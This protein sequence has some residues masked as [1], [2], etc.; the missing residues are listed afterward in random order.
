[1]TF[2]IFVTWVL[3]GVLVGLAAGMV[4]KQGGL[5][6]KNDIFLGVAG[7]IGMSWLLRGIGL[8]SGSSMVAAAFV[9]LL[10]A[11][12]AIAVQRRLRPTKQTREERADVWWR[13]GLGAV[14]VV[15][16]SWM[17]LAPE[18]QSVA[19]AA[20]TED[21]TYAV[22]PSSMKLKAGLVTGEVT[23][24]KITE[25]VE[26]GSGRVVATAKLTARIALKNSSTN[27]TVR[28]VTGKV[29]YIDAKGQPIKLEDNRA[30]PIVKFSSNDRLDPG[31]ETTESLDVDFPAEALKA[32]ALKSIRLD[33]VY[34]PSPYR[35][36]TV[37]LPVSVGSK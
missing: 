34:I 20:P 16:M 25:R 36:E 5:G 17:L 22:T 19:T 3:M 18:Q 31:Q 12:L 10:G 37:S 32:S 30:D 15:I 14:V 33:L 24:M 26:Q 7:S 35:E 28:L 8:V 6:L 13:Y 9:A 29:L 2:A 27:Q 23:D 11:T 21:K 1:M 4:V